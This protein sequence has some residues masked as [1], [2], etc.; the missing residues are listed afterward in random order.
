MMKNPPKKSRSH[1]IK[2]IKNDSAVMVGGEDQV[3]RY[4]SIKEDVPQWQ[5]RFRLKKKYRM[6]R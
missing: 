1:T 4:F 2:F 5:V 6:M 3:F